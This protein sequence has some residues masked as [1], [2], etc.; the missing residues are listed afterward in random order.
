MKNSVTECS[1]S[2]RAENA[3]SKNIMTSKRR[4]AKV[5]PFMTRDQLN[6]KIDAR[7]R[8]D[9]IKAISARAAKLDW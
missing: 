6:E 7:K 3:E 2:E 4:K 1:L 8:A 9:A 5:T